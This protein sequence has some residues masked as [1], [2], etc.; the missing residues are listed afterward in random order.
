[1]ARGASVD[2]AAS[3][4]RVLRYMRRDPIR[5][6][7]RD[8]CPHVIGLVSPERA[9]MEAAQL[10]V[11]EQLRHDVSL[12][13]AC[14]LGQLEVDEETM[15]VLHQGVAHVGQLRLEAAPLLGQTCLRIGRTL[16]C[17]VRTL[18]TAEVDRRIAR[19]IG[20]GVRRWLVLGTEALQTGGGLNQRAV[21]SEVLIR[22]QTQS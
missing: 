6:Q 19:V 10:R 7:G 17:G 4:I 21:D 9:W 1:M 22:Q 13:G 18:L 8:T 15:A 14:S 11:V 5:A 20:R 2:G 3:M 12:S 16:V